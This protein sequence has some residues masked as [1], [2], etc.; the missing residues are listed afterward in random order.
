MDHVRRPGRVCVPVWPCDVG[1]NFRC[2]DC[3]HMRPRSRTRSWPNSIRV[4]A[5]RISLP[6]RRSSARRTAYRFAR[7]AKFTIGWA[8]HLYYWVYPGVMVATMGVMIGYI[9]GSVAPSH[10][11]RGRTR[12]GFHGADRDHFLIR[13]RVDRVSGRE[14]IDQRQHRDQCDP[15]RRAPVLLRRWRSRTAWDIPRVRRVWR[16]TAPRRCCTTL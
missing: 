4:R 1:R 13:G 5:V 12:P 6:S 7:I 9:V 16:W 2:P 10:D 11:E 8:S 15:N 3:S 14:R